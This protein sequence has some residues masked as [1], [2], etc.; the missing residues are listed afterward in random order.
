ML[1]ACQGR[2]RM[3]KDLSGS[4]ERRCK[5]VIHEQPPDH[6]PDL[7]ETCGTSVDCGHPDAAGFDAYRR[8]TDARSWR[9]SPA[10]PGLSL[11]KRAI[12]KA[13]EHGLLSVR[14]TQRL[15][16]LSQCWEA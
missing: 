5:M 7:W 13:H 1:E 16:D 12:L 11:I 14:T 2:E 6:K 8:E 15:I 3:R 10:V 9:I 4:I